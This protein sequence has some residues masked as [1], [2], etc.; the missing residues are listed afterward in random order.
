LAQT[1]SGFTFVEK[2]FREELG[3]DL[4]KI[5]STGMTECLKGS[6]HARSIHM[7]DFQKPFNFC[8]KAKRRWTFHGCLSS[9]LQS[10]MFSWKSTSACQ[11]YSHLTDGATSFSK[12]LS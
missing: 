5:N 11:G 12:I 6:S 2:A 9:A 4:K 7:S 3:Q 1:V 10:M 8:T